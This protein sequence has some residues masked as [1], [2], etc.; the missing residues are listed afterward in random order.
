MKRKTITIDIR[1]LS[2]DFSR[3]DYV[4]IFYNEYCM[5]ALYGAKPYE[6]K[7]FT[8]GERDI[9]KLKDALRKYGA[10]KDY[11]K[12]IKE[13]KKENKFN[14][15]KMKKRFINESASV[16]PKFAN[17]FITVASNNDDVDLKDVEYLF[18]DEYHYIDDIIDNIE[19]LTGDKFNTEDDFYSEVIANAE[20]I[21]KYPKSR[22]LYNTIAKYDDLNDYP[23]FSDENLQSVSKNVNKPK[24]CDYDAED[25][26]EVVQDAFDNGEIV[27][28]NDLEDIMDELVSRVC[29]NADMLSDDEYNELV[30]AIHNAWESVDRTSGSYD[31][32]ED[33]D[34]FVSHRNRKEQT[35][36]MRHFPKDDS[37]NEGFVYAKLEDV[38][39]EARE[40]GRRSALKEM[41]MTS[42]E[43]PVVNEAK[44]EVPL[45]IR[46]EDLRL[47]KREFAEKVRELKSLGRVKGIGDLTKYGETFDP[48]ALT[49]A[50]NEYFR[51]EGKE[52]A[53]R[54]KDAIGVI[55]ELKKLN[56]TICVISA[57]IEDANDNTKKM[58]S[59]SVTSKFSKFRNEFRK[60]NESEEDSDNEEDKEE[61]KDSEKADDVKDTKKEDVKDTDKDADK[62]GDEEEEE[63]DIPAVVITVKKDAV[64][65]CKEDMIS[66]GVDEDDIEVLE[67]EDEDA[68][69]VE[70]K[71]DTNSIL[72]LKD[73]LESK[74]IDLEE[75]LGVTIES[76]D[77]EEDKEDKKDDKDSD[78]DE[79][80]DD[81]F[82]NLDDDFFANLGNVG[83]ED[84]DK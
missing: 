10:D 45:K 9:N 1:E 36:G 49:D 44:K 16:N 72:E 20:T 19:D 42:Q 8:Y 37:Y 27:T 21:V 17:A 13:S 77:E 82:D 79:D 71:V 29:P 74:G 4:Y 41:R 64:D 68:E 28:D 59:E 51:G 31:E 73:Y 47:A 33:D 25:C 62:E 63:V 6:L 50:Y 67:P 2:K 26:L 11:I 32:Y 12:T 23:N 43:K 30:D 56:V 48:K 40:E 58:V 53:D 24:K 34:E 22:L 75:K 76:D 52:F 70:I 83:G 69:E 5:Q 35:K 66:A 65:K 78:K 61:D 54:K 55:R 80:D 38:I 7:V 84:D 60:L 15:T 57:A 39:N 18:G 14:N 81:S 46:K 3:R